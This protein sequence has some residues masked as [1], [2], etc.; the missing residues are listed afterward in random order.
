MTMKKSLPDRPA[1]LALVHLEEQIAGEW[2]R[3]RR[4]GVPL[5]PVYG[6]QQMRL[7]KKIHP[8]TEYRLVP[9]QEEDD[10]IPF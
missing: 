2:V 8:G 9:L 7:L 1:P 5:H 4:Y 10:D 3:Q 6:A